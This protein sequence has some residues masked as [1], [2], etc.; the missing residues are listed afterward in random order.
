MLIGASCLPVMA[1]TPASS[2]APRDAA[3]DASQSGQT[4]TV[5]ALRLL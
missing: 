1:A 2:A 3:Q 4:M 5:T